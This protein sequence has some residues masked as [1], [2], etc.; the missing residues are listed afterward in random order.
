[1]KVAT[2]FLGFVLIQIVAAS[3]DEYGDEQVDF[4][5]SPPFLGPCKRVITAMDCGNWTCRAEAEPGDCV[6]LFREFQTLVRRTYPKEDPNCD[7][8][9]TIC[10]RIVDYTG[11][12]I[13]GTLKNLP[14]IVK[15][16]RWSPLG[17]FKWI[18]GSSEA[19]TTESAAETTEET[20]YPDKYT[21]QSHETSP[22]THE[23]FTTSGEVSVSETT[24]DAGSADESTVGPDEQPV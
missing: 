13:R 23:H 16:R 18:F 8:R 7:Q 10:V 1:L 12:S 17:V 24:V 4:E 22:D 20:V 3:Y 21:T 14:V 9:E 15:A 5:L 11:V 2:G 6:D 19:K